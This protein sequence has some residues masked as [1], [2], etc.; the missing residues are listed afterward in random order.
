M[1]IA[2]IW[3]PCYTYPMDTKFSAYNNHRYGLDKF[4]EIDN[5]LRLLREQVYIYQNPLI[6]ELPKKIPG[7]YTIGGGRQKIGR[8]S[9]RERVYVL[10]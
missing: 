5:H 4:W 3:I 10:V 8:A 1:S 6:K 2:Q 7:I 9:C